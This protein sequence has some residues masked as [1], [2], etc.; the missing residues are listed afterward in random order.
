MKELSAENFLPE[1]NKPTP[2]DIKLITRLTELEAKKEELEK[3]LLEADEEEKKFIELKLAEA[4]K[5]ITNYH[6]SF[7]IYRT[8]QKYRKLDEDAEKQ[9]GKDFVDDYKKFRG[10]Q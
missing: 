9:L 8:K 10:K 5:R 7:G 2:P 1:T 6:D 3:K 4:N